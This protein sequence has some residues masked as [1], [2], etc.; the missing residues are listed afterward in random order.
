MFNPNTYNIGTTLANLALDL[1]TVVVVFA[2]R[3]SK[4]TIHFNALDIYKFSTFLV[5]TLAIVDASTLIIFGQDILPGF[6]SAGLQATAAGSQISFAIVSVITILGVGLTVFSHVSSEIKTSNAG[7]TARLLAFTVFS[8][9]FYQRASMILGLMFGLFLCGIM[10]RK[11][12]NN[13]LTKSISAIALVFII[14]VFART[15]ITDVVERV[16]GFSI[17]SAQVSFEENPSFACKIANSPNQEH[18]QVW[19]VTISYVDAYGPDHYYNLVAA[20]FRPFLNSESRDTLGL[21]TSV[22][23][24]NIYNDS[25]NYLT[26]NFGFSLSAMS[27]HYYSLGPLF[28]IVF[29]ILGLFT[30]SIE[31]LTQSKK[32]DFKRTGAL[33]VSFNLLQLFFG[34]IDEQLKWLVINIVGYYI[35]LVLFRTSNALNSILKP[36]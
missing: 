10:N 26:K 4:P 2:T 22:D 18:D 30:T 9:I 3:M 12:I 13:S 27:Y 14:A 21:L 35:L 20:V 25:S 36:S 28:L 32:I 11:F 33:F 15:F 17:N 29:P 34:A 8:M 24:L 7:V 31:N 1:F 23:S 5:F 19:P 6:R 16:V